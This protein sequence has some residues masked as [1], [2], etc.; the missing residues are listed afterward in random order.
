MILKEE[1]EMRIKLWTLP[2]FSAV[3][4]AGCTSQAAMDKMTSKKERDDVIQIAE[5]LCDPARFPSLQAKFDAKVWEDSQAVIAEARQ[6][7]PKTKGASRLIGYK[8]NVDSTN[9]VTTRTGQYDLVTES[10]GLWTSTTLEIDGTYPDF[11]ISGWN[12]NGSPTKPE[13]LVQLDQW[14][15]MVPTIRLGLGLFLLTL[16]GL[17]GLIIFLV[18]RSRKRKQAVSD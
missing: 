17:I 5:S 2:I 1:R 13:D 7:C 4:L 14:D 12:L 10:P 3:A 6:F 11:K 9:G 18:L 15:K 16:A 8:S